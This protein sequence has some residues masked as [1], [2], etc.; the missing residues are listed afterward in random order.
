MSFSFYSASH[1]HSANYAMERCLSVRP[2]RVAGILSKWLNI[3]EV[4]F[5]PSSSQTI[6]V[7]SY[8]TGWQYS[9]G[10]PLTGASN[11]RGMK[12]HDFRP[13]SRK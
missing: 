12:N 8:Q 13:I 10:D 6:L 5:S 1:M 7:F 2:S 3:S 9:D 4:F 11:A